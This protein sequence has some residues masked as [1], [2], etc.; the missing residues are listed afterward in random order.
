MSKIIS[1]SIFTK[2]LRRFWPV[3]AGYAFVMFWAMPF[4]S[5]VN[6]FMLR[7]DRTGGQLEDSAKSFFVDDSIPMMIIFAVIMSIIVAMCVF[8]YMQQAASISFFHSLP[9]DKKTLFFTSYLSG[10]VMILAPNAFA[11]LVT[12]LICLCNNIGVF[13]EFLLWLLATTVIALFFYSLMTLCMVVSGVGPFAM[14]IYFVASLY[15]LGMRM[16]IEGI[17]SQVSYGLTIGSS[18]LR[19]PLGILSPY[20]FFG[21]LT[22]GNIL[23]RSGAKGFGEEAP[24]ILITGF[25]V[26][27]LLITAAFL[28]YRVRKSEESGNFIAIGFLKPVFRWGFAVSLGTL[29]TALLMLTTESTTMSARVELFIGGLVF[30]TIGFLAAQ[31]LIMKSFRVFKKSAKE[32][33]VFLGVVVAACFVIVICSESASK[34][35]PRPE[36]VE[37]VNVYFGGIAGTYA[38]RWTDDKDF[39]RELTEIHHRII[40]ERKELENYYE[41]KLLYREYAGFG[42]M[43][44]TYNDGRKT[45]IRNYRIPTDHP[46]NKELEAL[47]DKYA[48]VLAFGDTRNADIN[49]AFAEIMMGG[50]DTYYGSVNGESTELSYEISAASCREVFNAV[51]ADVKDKKLS[52]NDIQSSSF[53][54]LFPYGKLGND[55]YADTVRNNLFALVFEVKNINSEKYGYTIY[56][57]IYVN[58]RCDNIRAALVN[59]GIEE[60]TRDPR[61]KVEDVVEYQ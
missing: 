34:Y 3:W 43:N 30:G 56:Y 51:I 4:I 14:V 12:F 8:G 22:F 52:L 45:I 59:A 58:D 38:E 10:F 41:D 42:V 15:Y 44:I 60:I 37:S 47:A 57:T 1:K 11:G 17:G 18:S 49:R 31:M 40:D 39:I 50:T 33:A 55:R 24:M 35:V 21:K 36:E 20:E 7:F 48:V 5:Y 32:L 6:L 19:G 23:F 13:T 28:L 53:I 2:N 29:L 54:D 46:I 25:I 27:I 16:L 9:V 26:S 61:N